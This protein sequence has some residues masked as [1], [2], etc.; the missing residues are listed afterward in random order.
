M[1]I[2]FCRISHDYIATL[3]SK[4]DGKTFKTFREFSPTAH[5]RFRHEIMEYAQYVK[6]HLQN[7][8]YEPTNPDEVDTS[9]VILD[10]PGGLP[11]LPSPVPGI[12]GEETA[13]RGKEIIRAYFLRHYR[14]FYS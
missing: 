2:T 9:P 6:Q 10:G 3:C 8:H 7:V 4:Y 11:L 14:T 5:D 13:K 1:S 12:R